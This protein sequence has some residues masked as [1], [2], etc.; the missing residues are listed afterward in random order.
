MELFVAV[1]NLEE[2]GC[3]KTSIRLWNYKEM[4]I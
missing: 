3:Y 4:S 1:D 2:C